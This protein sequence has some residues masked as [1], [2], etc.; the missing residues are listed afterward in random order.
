MFMID[1]SMRYHGSGTGIRPFLA[2]SYAASIRFSIQLIYN[3]V[4]G[5]TIGPRD[6]LVALGSFDASV[7]A[8]WDL[9]SYYD[10]HQLLQAISNLRNNIT[11]KGH[12]DVENAVQSVVNSTLSTQHGDRPSYANDVVLITDK[13]SV[14]HND[15]LKHSLQQKSRDIIVVS[16]GNYTS[17]NSN[18]DDLA[19]A[20]DHVVHVPSYSALTS[21]N[22]KLLKLLCY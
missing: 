22:T 21:A 5:L 9:R 16:L 13:S 3:V 6:N 8:H 14:F 2:S 18:V 10:K 4:A 1:T 7:H 20:H 15:I 19:T 17:P 12:G 11:F